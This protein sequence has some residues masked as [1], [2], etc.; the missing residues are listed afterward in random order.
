MLSGQQETGDMADEASFEN[1]SRALAARIVAAYLR[2]NEIGADQLPTLIT[3]VHQALANIGKPP[4]TQPAERVPAVPIR[5]SI[6]AN[7]VVCLECGWQGKMLRRHV[8]TAHGLGAGEYRS[9]WNLSSAHLMVA[10]AYSAQRS[11]M[12]K[13]FGLG[14]GRAVSNEGS[15]PALSALA[16]AS[17]PAPRRRGRPPRPRATNQPE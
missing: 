8:G 6:T 15:A 16:P 7:F 11:G 5:R 10:P 3:T 1:V 4:Q 17:E 13:Q 9:R 14:R 12:A 2:R